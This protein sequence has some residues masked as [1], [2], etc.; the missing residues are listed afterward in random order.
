MRISETEVAFRPCVW[1]MDRLGSL[2]RLPI[3]PGRVYPADAARLPTVF[4]LTRVSDFISV[5]RRATNTTRTGKSHRAR[6]LGKMGR[7]SG[8][9]ART[10]AEDSVSGGNLSPHRPRRSARAARTTDARTGHHTW[11]RR[12]RRQGWRIALSVG[13][14]VQPVRR[15][16]E[17]F[18]HRRPHLPLGSRVATHQG[19]RAK[20]DDQP[21]VLHGRS[22]RAGSRWARPYSSAV[23][24]SREEPPPE[25][26]GPRD[27]D[28]ERGC[29][30]EAARPRAGRSGRGGRGREGLLRPDLPA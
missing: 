27:G 29:D 17:L 22:L 16:R 7:P 26:T 3:F 11:A 2:R 5:R 4:G 20:C 9:D 12:L 1:D 14:V 8:L 24:P 15:R 30:D 21:N 28:G 13:R 18:R 19:S 6:K 23:G 10:A 25:R